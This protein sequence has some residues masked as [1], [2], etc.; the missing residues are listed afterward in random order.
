[1]KRLKLNTELICYSVSDYVKLKNERLNTTVKLSN[2]H[3]TYLVDGKWIGQ[4]EFNKLRPMPTYR[5]FNEKG[6]TIGSLLK[7]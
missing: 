4:E 2:G 6:M 5:K 7:D 3:Y 1:M